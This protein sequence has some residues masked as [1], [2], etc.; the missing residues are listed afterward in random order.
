[1]K[2]PELNIIKYLILILCFSQISYAQKTI[3]LKPD[4]ILIYNRNFYLSDII[5]ARKDTGSI[6][7][8]TDKQE[9]F[10]EQG[11]KLAFL[12][13][14]FTALPKEQK[15][16]IPVVL[17][18]NK[19]LVTEENEYSEIATAIA[20]VEFMVKSDEE[21][22]SIFKTESEV[23]ESGSGIAASHEKRIRF[24][25]YDCLKKFSENAWNL[26]AKIKNV[27]EI[28]EAGPFSEKKQDRGKIIYDNETAKSKE[29]IEKNRKRQDDDMIPLKQKNIFAVGFLLGGICLVGFEYEI[30]VH[31]YIGLNFGAG[32]PGFTGGIKIHTGS[33][34]DSHFFNLSFKD[35]YYGL[36]NAAGI[37]WGGRWVFRDGKKLGLLYQFGLVYQTGINK[38]LEKLLYNGKAYSKIS[39]FFGVGLS[40]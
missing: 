35:F 33:G 2:F 38:D 39:P 25:L 14:F 36:M 32:Y 24:V 26:G 8:S 23:R 16:Q 1:M 34:R 5:D 21:L 13:Y 11:V 30:R 19:I 18:V 17:K 3:N 40:W 4:K 31:N 37:E 28:K 29:K 22:I 15:R 20:E 10:I 27:K 6:G 12:N 9:I 7:I